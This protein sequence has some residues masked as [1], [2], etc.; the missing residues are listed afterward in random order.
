MNSYLSNLESLE[1][2]MNA[3]A[4]ETPSLGLT[5]YNVHGKQSSLM[6]NIDPAKDSDFKKR[7]I[8]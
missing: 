2:K 3:A 5:N 6:L 8:T 1:A 7:A 4:N